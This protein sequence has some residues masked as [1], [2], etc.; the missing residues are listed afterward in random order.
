[1]GDG[2]RLENREAERTTAPL[3]ILMKSKEYEDIRHL[4]TKPKPNDCSDILPSL[5][6]DFGE[7]RSFDQSGRLSITSNCKT[8]FS[9]GPKQGERFEWSKSGSDYSLSKIDLA[10]G[11]R[12]EFNAVTGDWLHVKQTDR[13][14]ERLKTSGHEATFDLGYVQVTVNMSG[15]VT[16]DRLRSEYQRVWRTFNSDS[17]ADVPF[18][19]DRFDKTLQSLRESESIEPKA[20]KDS[21]GIWTIGVGT[22]LEAP[23]ARELLQKVGVDYDLMMRSRNNEDRPA[24]T[25]TQTEQLLKI[26]TVKALFEARR[27]YPNY[28]KMPPSAQSALI[29]LAFN[30]GYDTLSK[31]TAFNELVNKGQFRS[32]GLQLSNSKYRKQVGERAVNNM[33]L[34][35][36]AS[37]E[38]D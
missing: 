34:L 27:L 35:A 18:D 31:F 36:A 7:Q 29:D 38:I 14:E 17:L 16:S 11:T 10:D 23:G 19:R 28:D 24:L 3:D 25:E 5:T 9:Y 21:R 22:N 30:M 12:Y 37:T 8:V 2:R 32:A 13:G 6:L 20:Y 26:S 1:M 33:K 4:F 15:A